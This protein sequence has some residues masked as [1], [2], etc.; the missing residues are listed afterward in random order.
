MKRAAG[1]L[2]LSALSALAGPVLA[3]EG[4]VTRPARVARDIRELAGFGTRHTLSRDD[5][6]CRGIA[7]ARRY[8][9]SELAEAAAASAGRMRVVEDSWV[10]PAD[11]AR[12]PP[13]AP[14]LVN[15]LAVF[16]GADPVLAKEAIL[17]SGHYDSRASDALDAVSDAPGA[18]D[19]GSGTT[20]VLEA[21]RA[22]A[23]LFAA[24]PPR[25]TVVLAALPGEE[26]GL[27][28][29]KRL[30][31]WCREKGLVPTAVLNHDIV[32]SPVGPD[33]ARREKEIRLFSGNRGGEDGPARNLARAIA[34]MAD[35]R[36]LPVRPHLVFRR[37]RRG[38]GGDQIPFEEAGFAAV[39]FT[40]PAEV[41][42][43]QH[44]DVRKEG[45][46][47]YGDLPEHVDP[48]YLARV[49]L[50]A[51][52]AAAELATAPPAPRDPKLAGTVSHDTALTWASEPGV[53]YEVLI[54]DTASPVWQEVRP[55]PRGR[56]ALW[57]VAADDRVF[58]VRA[59]GEDGARGIP[60]VVGE[61]AAR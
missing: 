15:V 6:P 25:R 8:L 21:A 35:R 12:I 28:G 40:E 34:E 42:D 16:D 31:A 29:G 26:Q 22:L 48:G 56:V 23:P 10:E 32:G 11:G 45:A 18:D 5:V 3:G 46:R 24:R 49:A 53:S 38:R 1:L 37:D 13:P 9:V 4:P 39:R 60:V 36:A 57:N 59:V 47:S 43:R 61:N 27:Y 17:V 19:D 30:L 2:L 52:T 33:G 7:A 54:R 44:Q 55:A 14:T 41:Y 20:V 50:L 58:A 51:A